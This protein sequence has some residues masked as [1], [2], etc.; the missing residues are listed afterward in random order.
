VVTNQ[1]SGGMKKGLADDGENLTAALGI[2]WA[3]AVNVR[4]RLQNKPG[5]ESMECLVSKSPCSARLSFQYSIANAGLIFNE[6]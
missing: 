1:V 4:Y 3:H 2:T 5:K 6:K